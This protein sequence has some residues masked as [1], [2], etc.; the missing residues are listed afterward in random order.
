MI[1]P[2]HASGV[3]KP[4]TEEEMNKEIALLDS[5]RIKTRHCAGPLP[6]PSRDIE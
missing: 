3:F 2:L 5:Q 6:S 1:S 4:I